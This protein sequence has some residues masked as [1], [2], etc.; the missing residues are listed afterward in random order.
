VS[1]RVVDE[2][3][4]LL[5]AAACLGVVLAPALALRWAATHGGMGDL[6]GLDLVVASTLVGTGQAF[7]AHARLRSEE[8]TA[9]RRVDMWIAAGNALV[10]LALGATL[11]L[12]VVLH[13]FPGEHASMANS[14]YPVVVLWAGVQA[15]AVLCA[16]TTGRVVFWWLEPHEPTRRLCH[17]SVLRRPRPSALGAGPG[18]PTR[19]HVPRIA[20]LRSR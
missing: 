7:V 2:L 11:L 6:E 8:R 16:E 14:G 20:R 18:G 9:V 19:A 5:Y 10:V 17:W 1:H 4:A 12:L 3:V 13:S 15:V